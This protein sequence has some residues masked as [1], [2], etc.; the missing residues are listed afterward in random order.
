MTYIN[1]ILMLLFFALSL[2]ALLEAMHESAVEAG[3]RVAQLSAALFFAALSMRAGVVS[4][5]LDSDGW[6]K[7]IRSER[8]EA[9]LA[10]A[11]IGMTI[12]SQGWIHIGSGVWAY[13][14]LALG[15]VTLVVN[16]YVLTWRI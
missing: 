16:A 14:L 11:A 15:T 12:A 2:L 9:C 10:R 3:L 4:L 7:W 1:R 6:L 5:N 13:A 8:Q